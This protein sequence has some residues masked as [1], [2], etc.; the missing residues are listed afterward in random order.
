MGNVHEEK[1]NYVFRKYR[2]YSEQRVSVRVWRNGKS[3]VGGEVK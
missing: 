2:N 3:S 1:W